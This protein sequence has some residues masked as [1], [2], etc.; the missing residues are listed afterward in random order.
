MDTAKKIIIISD[1][2]GQTAKRLLD[3]VLAQYT[4]QQDRFAVE[5]IYQNVRT[6]KRV[7]DILQDINCDCLVI[8]SMVSEDLSNYLHAFLEEQRILHLNVLEPMLH[9]M[10]KFLGVHPTYQPGLLQTIDDRYY[11]KVD[12]IGFT[13]EHDDGRGH[14]LNEAELVLVGPSR[15]C[16]TPISMY[17]TCNYGLRV[18]NIPIVPQPM[19]KEQLLER[20]AG[21][22]PH[23]VFGLLMQ[24]D[25]L[26]K[27][28]EE[29]A[30]LLSGSESGLRHL[31]GYQDL[32]NIREELRFCRLLY[33]EQGWTALDVTSRAIEE[34]A[35]DIVRR[36][37]TFRNHRVPG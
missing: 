10:W 25:A 13:A 22:D 27:V 31:K 7:D 4:E 30:E 8:Y 20:L 34:V 28:R 36:L 11:K 21:I 19:M 17:T 5:R 12:A 23:L 14:R 2:T 37:K 9:T 26:T 18:A 29:R 33:E 3:A 35:L 24:P 6:K 16:K 1:G 32:Q 15:T